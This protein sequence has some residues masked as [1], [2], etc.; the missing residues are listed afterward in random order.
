MGPCVGIC[1]QREL[2]AAG[3]VHVVSKRHG[4]VAIGNIATA[5]EYR[6]RGYA[7]V[8]TRGLCRA[9][10]ETHLIALNVRKD[11]APALACHRG[12]GFEPV[13]VYEEGWVRRIRA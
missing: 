7:G 4:V 10:T 11:N 5:P 13:V 8:I 3:G 2:V 1:E 9:L 6:G 12:V